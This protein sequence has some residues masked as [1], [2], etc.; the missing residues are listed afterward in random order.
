[1]LNEIKEYLPSDVRLYD[2]GD[3]NLCHCINILQECI[4]ENTIIPLTDELWDCEFYSSLQYYLKEIEAAMTKDGKG[5]LFHSMKEEIIEYLQD[6]DSSELYIQLLA[7]TELTCFY[8]L[9]WELGEGELFCNDSV[10]KTAYKIRRKLGLH[11]NTQEGQEIDNMCY[12]ATYGGM[13]RIY[14]KSNMKDFL[15]FEEN[16]EDFRTIHF[17]GKV[18][19]AIYNPNV[20]AG[21]FCYVKIDKKFPFLRENLSISKTETYH[22]EDCFGLC[23]DWL[24]KCKAPKFEYRSCHGKIKRSKTSQLRRR[25]AEYKKVF[26]SGGCSVG[27]MNIERHHDV[28]YRFEYPCGHRCPH[29]GTFWPD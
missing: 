21:D 4:N 1:M 29:C 22:L 10:I 18:A 5:E 12:Q 6:K 17:K 23:G 24:D 9:G 19:L 25:E 28:Y 15:T 8:D 13:L 20:G 26:E 27:D 16:E 11:I 7:N 2:V 14:F 3:S